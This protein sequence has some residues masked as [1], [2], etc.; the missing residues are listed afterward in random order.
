MT[1]QR[2]RACREC[3]TRRGRGTAGDPS[4]VQHCRRVCWEAVLGGLAPGARASC[5]EARA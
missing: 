1:L 2:K 3:R 4:T 5:C